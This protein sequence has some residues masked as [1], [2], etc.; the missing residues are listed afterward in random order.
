MNAILHSVF[1]WLAAMG[2][3]AILA[4]LPTLIAL[5]R[6]A[7]DIGYLIL[8]NVICCATVF[9]WPIALVAAIA[10][11]RR[12]PR[13]RRTPYQRPLAPLPHHHYRSRSQQRDPHA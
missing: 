5:A 1:F 11:P 13:P 9:G 3:L 8:V 12:N 6:G 10:W 4:V 7:D 2:L